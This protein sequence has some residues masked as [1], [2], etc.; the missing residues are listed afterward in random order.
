MKKNSVSTFKNFRLKTGPDDSC[1]L[2]PEFFAEI[3]RDQAE[4]LRLLD[5]NQML[6]K[7]IAD[8]NAT[9]LL[10]STFLQEMIQHS[11]RNQSKSKY[12]FT[13][14]DHMREVA[15]Y[16]F[17]MSG[18]TVYKTLADNLKGSL[19][20]LPSVRKILQGKESYTEGHFR[21]AEIK[22]MMEDKGEPMFVVISEDDTKVTE[23]LRYDFNNDTIMGL[24]LPLNDNGVPVADAFKFTTLF[25]VQGY[26]TNNSM[27]TYTKLMTV[28][29]LSTN[30][31]SYTLV[32]YG[33]KGSDTAAEVRARVE[34]VRE[35]FAEIGIT[36]VGKI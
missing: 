28:T 19:P 22:K 26:L 29:P 4:I 24:N 32:V 33:T 23:R 6:K 18:P 5:S 30:S 12:R 20:S 16:I 21:F 36:V 34:Y 27:S 1:R 7:Q 13:Y 15:L 35:S 10:Q 17:V 3:T 9:A 2:I 8:S 14:T 11:V 31:T 25:D